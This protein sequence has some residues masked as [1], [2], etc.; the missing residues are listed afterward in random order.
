LIGHI[1]DLGDLSVAHALSLW[2]LEELQDAVLLIGGTEG[3][4]QPDPAPRIRPG[5]PQVWFCK[6]QPIIT[7][8]IRRRVGGL[9]CAVVAGRTGRTGLASFSA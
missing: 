2:P 8:I 4:A 5:L 9:A 7:P 6:H 1:A 3:P